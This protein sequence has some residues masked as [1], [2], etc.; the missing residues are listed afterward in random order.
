MKVEVRY[1]PGKVKARASQT[2]ATGCQEEA[3]SKA[4]ALTFDPWNTPATFRPRSNL[5]RSRRR[6]YDASVEVWARRLWYPWSRIVGLLL[7]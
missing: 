4:P 3:G 6:V 1:P 5:N 7:P 2:Q